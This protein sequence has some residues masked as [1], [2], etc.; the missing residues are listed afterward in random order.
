MRLK[1]GQWIHLEEIK[2]EIDKEAEA[3]KWQKIPDLVFQF[4][5]ACGYEVDDPPWMDI[6]KIYFQAVEE[7]RPRISFPLFKSREKG[8]QRPWDYAERS[9]YFWLNIFA[10]N[11]G[12][13]P[14]VVF[15]LDLDDAIGLY[16]EILVDEQFEKEWVYSLS[17]IAYPYDKNTKKS[18]FKPLGKPDWMAMYDHVP[19]Q[20]AKTVKIPVKA[21]PI[22]EIVALDE[23]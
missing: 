12:W 6:Q 11:Y 9:K 23:T 19:N 14:D 7:N 17:E 5:I 22:G 4:I 15:D 20:P 13:T 10:R 2:K 18:R 8:K 21:M 3:G 1:F 16:E